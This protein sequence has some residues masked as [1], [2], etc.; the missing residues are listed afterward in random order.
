MPGATASSRKK[1]K[2]PASGK[3]KARRAVGVPLEVPELRPEA[4]RVLNAFYRRRSPVDFVAAG[5]VLKA[6]ASGGFSS[7]NL[8]RNVVIRF[9][10][11]GTAGAIECPRGLIDSL[12]AKLQ[13]E[14][15]LARLAPDL[16]ALLLECVLDRE[17]GWLEVQLGTEIELLWVG[18]S[19][20]R[21]AE[22]SSLALAVGWHEEM[23][24]CDL[25]LENGWALRLARLLDEQQAAPPQL[26]LDIPAPVRVWRAVTILALGEL[27]SLAPGDVVVLDALHAADRTVLILLA[28]HFLA[29]AQLTG[30]G[31]TLVSKPF[32][33]RGSNWEWIMN[34]TAHP[35][36]EKPEESGFDGLPVTVAF[37]LGRK[38]MPLS[39]ISAL[40]PGAV[41]QLADLPREAVSIMAQGKQI[42]QG[43]IVRI[44]DALGVRIA[45]IFDNA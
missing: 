8:G 12:L 22:R 6:T 36:T 5:E 37:E 9:Y 35:D 28:D 38:A 26:R 45:R 24:D 1:V 11:G 40:A 33:I 27:Q 4:V 13:P 41:V 15:D 19:S 7:Q 44:G 17:I 23:L 16:A 31:C 42:G 32:T 29:R 30:D 3:P 43:E 10:I 20:R 2:R 34:K 39:E 18:E 25:Q 21:Q 14:V